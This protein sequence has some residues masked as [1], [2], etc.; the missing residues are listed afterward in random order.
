M[1]IELNRIQ[2]EGKEL[3]LTLP[4]NNIILVGATGRQNK[5]VRK[6]MRLGLESLNKGES[7]PMTFLVAN[8]LP[9]RMLIGCDMLRLSLIHI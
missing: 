1:C 9:F 3:I 7:I 6:Q 2:E 5:T 8:G 4:I